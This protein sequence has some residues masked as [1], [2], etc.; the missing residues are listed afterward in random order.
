MNRDHL[1]ACCSA[2]SDHW[3]LPQPQSTLRLVSTRFDPAHLHAEDFTRCAIEP[4]KGVAK[5]QTEYLAGRLCARAALTHLTGAAHTPGIGDDRAPQW[6]TG[7]LGAITHGSGWAGAVV[8]NSSQWRGL[9]LDVERIMPASRAQ[10]LAAEILTP[11]E[12][13][14]LAS[15]PAEL[16]AQR[17]SLTFSLK[18]SLFKALYPQ[19]LRRFYFQDAELVSVSAERKVGLR[20]LIDLHPDWPAGSE[21]TGQF[22]A[23]EGYLLSLVSIPR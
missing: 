14:R 20:L 12:Q 22:V 9:G 11:G 21:M 13:Q 10:R 23:F 19:V 8:G 4:V 1:P 6:P 15:L 16:H 7:T 18:E 3:P 2:L 5:R 17:I